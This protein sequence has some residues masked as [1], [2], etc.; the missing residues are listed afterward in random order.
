MN[1]VIQKGFSLIELIVF[2]VIIAVIASGLMLP[3]ATLVS[4]SD[5]FN[6]QTRAIALAELGME[7]AIGQK[8]LLGFN[9]I[10]TGT[11]FCGSPCAIGENT[12]H[13]T[14]TNLSTTHKKIISSV[15]GSGHATLTT[16]VTN[17]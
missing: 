8:R 3:F 13:V 16:I 11:V 15:S 10:S 7:G 4:D 12:L 14:V 1:T 17:Y 6:D 2:I 5:T 9:N